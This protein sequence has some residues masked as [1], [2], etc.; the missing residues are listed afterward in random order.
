VL[1]LAG[2]SVQ[3]LWYDEHYT[4]RVALVPLR[5][6]LDVLVAEEGSKPPLY[7]VFMHYWV[8]IS[9]SEFWLRASSAF[10]GGVDCV[11]AAAL[12]RQIFRHPRGILLGWLLVFAPFH[13]Y[14]SQ[15]AR[16]YALWGA[17][18]T[19]TLLFQVKFCAAPQRRY[20][21]GMSCQRSS[22]AIHSPTRSSFCLFR[23]CSPGCIAPGFPRS[24]AP[25]WQSQTASS[26][27]CTFPGS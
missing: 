11:A 16:P 19:L 5:D 1:R 6:L 15:E 22:P 24:I 2:I 13:I 3:N 7:F 25:K 20:L 17:L 26:C 27:S 10:F 9:S 12:G 23:C 21:A 18:V 8:K 14:Y 4:L